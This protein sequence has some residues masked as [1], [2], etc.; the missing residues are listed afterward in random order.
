MYS[1]AKGAHTSD[2]DGREKM[3]GSLSIDRENRLSRLE[4]EERKNGGIIERGN[5]AARSVP[6]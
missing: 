5:R 6:H 1:M 4:A 3:E 2:N